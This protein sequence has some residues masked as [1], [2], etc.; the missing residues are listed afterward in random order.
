[1]VDKM[2]KEALHHP[3]AEGSFLRFA[4]EVDVST[5]QPKLDAQGH[6]MWNEQWSD[7]LTNMYFQ[8]DGRPIIFFHATQ[9]A[10]YDD[11]SHAPGQWTMFDSIY[12]EDGGF[13]FGTAYAAESMFLRLKDIAKE[14]TGTTEK[15]GERSIPVITTMEAPL[16]VED[17]GGFERF[18]LNAFAVADGSWRMRMKSD[19]DGLVSRLVNRGKPGTLASCDSASV[20]RVVSKVENTASAFILQKQIRESD[21]NKDLSFEFTQKVLESFGY[22][23]IVYANSNEGKGADSVMV[24]DKN[25]LFSAI[26]GEHLWK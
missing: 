7:R 22:D 9:D 21:W 19:E 26:T 17:C 3:T 16:G 24:L 11:G 15:V 13:H 5:G 20:E 6:F 4:M 10:V 25:L 12:A 8:K 18:I 2:R 1:M 23:G 14:D